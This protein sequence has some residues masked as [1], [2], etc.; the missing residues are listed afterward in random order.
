MANYTCVRCNRALA[1]G[2]TCELHA[3]NPFAGQV[4]CPCCGSSDAT[5]P[6]D[7]WGR[8]WRCVSCHVLF[9]PHPSHGLIEATS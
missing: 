1:G 8:E 6:W 9:T 3:G 4:K 7:F 2:A 5:M